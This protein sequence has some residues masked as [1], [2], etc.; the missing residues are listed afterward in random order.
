M[1]RII[2]QFCLLL[3]M[4]LISPNAFA[5]C[6]LQVAGLATT[7]TVQID[8]DTIG[9]TAV[10]VTVNFTVQNTGSSSC[11]YFLTMDEGGVGVHEYNRY[12]N[13]THSFPDL[14]GQANSD[15]ISYQVYSQSVAANNIVKTLD[16]AQAAQ[17]V[18]GS[19]QILAG[20]TL[21]ES[22]TI[23]VPNQNLPDIIAE[24]YADGVIMTLYQN[25]N[26]V[27]DFANDCPTCTE[28]SSRNVQ[29]EFQVTD[30][31]TLVI[32]DQYDIPNS[33]AMLD[34]GVLRTNQEDYFTVFVGGRASSGTCTVT[35]SSANGSKL[36]RQDISGSPQSHDEIPYTVAAAATIGGPNVSAS[37]DLSTANSAVSLATSSVPFVC[38]NNNQGVMGMDVT[39]TIG[40]VDTTT[41]YGGTF[42]DTITIEAIVG[43]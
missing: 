43:L 32:G 28:V 38:G 3:F 10:T 42:Q 33:Q 39:V 18:L 6:N 16:D 26:A 15:L 31:A 24:G 8:A 17:N 20:Q 19:Q 34:F 13:I 37:I 30:F 27:I 40:T 12:A 23:H 22:F 9:A 29:F 1:F 41:L 2:V 36:I 25:P 21:N 7:Q 5:T 11:Y 14:Y 35:I 4:L